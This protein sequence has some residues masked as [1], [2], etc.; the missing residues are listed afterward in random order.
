MSRAEYMRDYR[1][2]KVLKLPTPEQRIAELEE[3]VAHLKRQLALHHTA[4]AV[5]RPRLVE[6][7]MADAWARSRPSPKSR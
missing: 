1:A 4:E 5:T 2:R 7:S 3:E 6:P